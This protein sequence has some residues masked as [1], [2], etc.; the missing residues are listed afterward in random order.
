[1]SGGSGRMSRGPFARYDR[2]SCSWKTY[3]LSLFE[4][5]PDA[6]LTWPRSGTWDLGAAYELPMSVPLTAGSGSSSSPGLLRTP[7]AQLAVNGGSQHPDKRKA[8]GHG[9]TLADEVEYLL[10]TPETGQSPNG[11]GIRGG[12]PGNGHQSG[13]SLDSVVTDLLP[14]P[15]VADSRNSRNATAGRSPGSAGHSGTTLS[16]VFREGALLPTPSMA[17][18]L[19]GHLSRSGD[20]GGELLLSGV[21]KT[22]LPTPAAQDSGNTPEEHLRKKPGRQQVTSLQVIVDHGLLPSGGRI[23]PSS[24]GGSTPPGGP[25]HAQLSL[26]EMDS[27]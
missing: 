17:D 26:D 3:Q 15:T 9:P 4:D 25:R 2:D 12:R 27:G 8:G 19:G 7:T 23:P 24:G 11:H 22:L 5:L 1:M 14:T 6:S 18:G 21:V 20:R 10:P 13:A 16:D